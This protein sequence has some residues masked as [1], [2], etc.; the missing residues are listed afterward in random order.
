MQHSEIPKAKHAELE[1]YTASKI[2]LQ[3]TGRMTQLFFEY[4]LIAR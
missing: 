2:Q 3:H 4:A 1:V